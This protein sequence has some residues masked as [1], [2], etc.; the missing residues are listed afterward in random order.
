MC[1]LAHGMHPRARIGSDRCRVFGDRGVLLR[2]GP[3]SECESDVAAG[4]ARLEL[5]RSREVG[6]RV[7]D[8]ARAQQPAAS[9]DESLR[10]RLVND[11]VCRCASERV[12]RCCDV[13]IFAPSR[14]LGVEWSLGRLLRSCFHVA[15]VS[16]D[17]ALPRP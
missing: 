17:A 3:V 1:P 10:R 11:G 5:Q 2:A 16:A 4:E 9:L 14:R 8:L 13:G 7:V 12:P 6:D 15:A